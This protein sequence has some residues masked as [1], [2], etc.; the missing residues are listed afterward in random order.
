MLI[1]VNKQSRFNKPKTFTSNILIHYAFHLMKL[2]SDEFEFKLV[3]LQLY[4]LE[5]TGKKCMNFV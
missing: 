4:R 5:D 2:E 3:Y 1:V